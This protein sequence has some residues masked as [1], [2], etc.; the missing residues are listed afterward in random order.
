MRVR[1]SKFEVRSWGEAF[2]HKERKERRDFI[3]QRRKG[4]KVSEK[5]EALFVRRWRKKL[6]RAKRESY[7]TLL[8]ELSV[9]AGDDSR[10]ISDE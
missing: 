7:E 5:K 1:G 10:L 4:R 8:G 9:L 3:A 2:N 6:S